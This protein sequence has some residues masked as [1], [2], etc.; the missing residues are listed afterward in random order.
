MRLSN[1]GADAAT[2]VLISACNGDNGSSSMPTSCDF[3]TPT[4][5][6]QKNYQE[7]IVDN[8]GNTIVET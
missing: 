2:S 6:A 3:V 5:D 7:T 1:L 4:A 8:L